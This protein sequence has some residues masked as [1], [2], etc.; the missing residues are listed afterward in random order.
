M[1]DSKNKEINDEEMQ[2]ATGG[3]ADVDPYGYLCD[4]TVGNG[5]GQGTTN[6]VETIDYSVDG[7]NGKGYWAVYQG[8][9]ELKP[10]TRVRITHVENGWNAGGYE[11]EVIG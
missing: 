3:A 7:D 11:I 5:T 6:G 9:G 8:A 4:G 1:A 2:N 10:G